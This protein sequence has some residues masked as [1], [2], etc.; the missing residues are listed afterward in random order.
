[1]A[2][3]RER[4]R[5]RASQ[6][7]ATMS[8]KPKRDRNTGSLAAGCPRGTVEANPRRTPADARAAATLLEGAMAATPAGVTFDPV[9]SVSARMAGWRGANLI[10]PI[11]LAFEEADAARRCPVASSWW[12]SRRTGCRCIPPSTPSTAT[13]A[14]STP[15]ASASSGRSSRT[16]RSRWRRWSMRSRCRPSPGAARSVSTAP[17]ASTS[18]TAA[19]ARKGS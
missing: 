3:H 15:A 10:E 11:Q 9:R 17:T 4:T 2:Y 16:T 5:P 13:G 19:A 18:A 6:D 1:M 8:A 14:W 12:W 7:M